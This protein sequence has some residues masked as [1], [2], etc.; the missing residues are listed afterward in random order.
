MYAGGNLV[1]GEI[2]Y[3][4]ESLEALTKNNL[5][6]LASYRGIPDVNMKMLKGDIIDAILKYDQPKAVEEE[7]PPMSV[8]IKRIR[9]SQ[10]IE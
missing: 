6:S 2:M 9:E 10:E 4:Y 5:V 1:E 7:L 3:S 8:R